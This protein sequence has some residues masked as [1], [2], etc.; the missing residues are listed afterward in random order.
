[1]GVAGGSTAPAGPAAGAGGGS[2]C[3][4]GGGSS[5]APAGPAAGADA[6]ISI[7]I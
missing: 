5:T 1:M 4:V 2:E 6:K 7:S 3:R